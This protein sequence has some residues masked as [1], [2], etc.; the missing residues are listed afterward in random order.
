MEVFNSKIAKYLL[1][2]HKAITVGF[3]TLYK[4]SKE[5]TK[6]VDRVHESIHRQQWRECFILLSPFFL[7]SGLWCLLPIFGFYIWYLVE[8]FISVVI[9]LIK[10]NHTQHKSY[11][12][13]SFEM[14]ACDKEREVNYLSKRSPFYWVKY[15]GDFGVK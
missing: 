10:R 3:I 11:R 15:L 1:G 8:H 2:G 13:I 12:S 14:E 9:S 4:R 7:L 6:E 5:K